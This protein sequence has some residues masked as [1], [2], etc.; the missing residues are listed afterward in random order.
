M[1]SAV[2]FL[3]IATAFCTVTIA[4]GGPQISLNLRPD[5]SENSNVFGLTRNRVATD[6]S[7]LRAP[8]SATAGKLERHVFEILNAERRSQGLTD[9]EW[10]DDVAAV[11]RLHSQNMAE[12]KFFS[13][14]GSDGSMVDDRADRMGLGAWRTI[15]ENIAYMRGYDDPAQLAVEKWLESTAH[16]KNL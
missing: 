12:E 14:R 1:K 5:G 15:G 6:N 3:L 4:Q 13:H 16:R 9:L 7:N 11:A 8:E 2:L 10:N